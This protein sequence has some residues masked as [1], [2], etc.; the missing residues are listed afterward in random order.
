MRHRVPA[1]ILLVAVVLAAPFFVVG[2]APS[3]TK[4]FDE[5]AVNTDAAIKAAIE[6]TKATAATT[7]WTP[8]RT[9]WGDPDLQG[10]YFNH[11]GYTPLERPS[12]Q[13]EPATGDPQ[14]AGSWVRRV[15]ART[16][17]GEHDRPPRPHA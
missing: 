17:N 2:Q 12:L 10:Y 16:S 3:G 9:P 5:T 1:V 11:S 14:A 15:A 7:N 8:P 6:A 4:T 13:S